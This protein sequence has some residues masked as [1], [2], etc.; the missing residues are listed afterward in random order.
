MKGS[1]LGLSRSTTPL[2]VSEGLMKTMKISSKKVDVPPNI[3]TG[4]HQNTNQD[5]VPL[6]TSCSVVPPGRHL[7][8]LINGPL[9]VHTCMSREVFC[10]PAFYLHFISSL[11]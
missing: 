5:G 3:R 4:Y 10:L 7:R 9:S 2:L 11:N 8:I 1:G 6:Q